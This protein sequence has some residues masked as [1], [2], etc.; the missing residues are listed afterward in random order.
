MRTPLSRRPSRIVLW[1]MEQITETPYSALFG[2][3]AGIVVCF[4]VV[5]F[6][7]SFLDGGHSLSR[8]Q[9]MEPL[10]RIGNSLYFSLITST[11]V[12]YGD[13]V[14]QGLGKFFAATE[15]VFGYF[16]FA[17]FIAKLLSSK[18]D[19]AIQEVHALMFEN[20]FHGTR[21][22]FFTIRKDFDAVILEAEE[23]QE[24]SDDAWERLAVAS[25]EGQRLLEGILGFY[26]DQ[27]EFVTLDV[28]RERLLLEAVHRTY[29]RLD[30]V[31]ETLDGAHV[32]WKAAPTAQDLHELA[33]VTAELLPE[34]KRVGHRE[35]DVWFARVR[36]AADALAA[37]TAATHKRH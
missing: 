2:V 34:W 22:G 32:N 17:V 26:S 12:G 29:G 9:E 3:W 15:A 37:R 28:K 25:W 21:E 8:L 5:F 6:A 19:L 1:L 10:Q 18:S 11:T 31:L 35:N 4:A 7:L 24:L 23:D 16:V 13:L 30:R 14:P 36:G 27:R 33:R 20:K